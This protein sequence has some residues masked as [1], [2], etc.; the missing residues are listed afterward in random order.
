VTTLSPLTSHDPSQPP[1]GDQWWMASTATF[2]RRGKIDSLSHCF[3]IAKNWKH[4]I[5]AAAVE[6]G[7]DPS[8]V[9]ATRLPAGSEGA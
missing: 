1:A 9:I 8:L 2:N 7:A 3:V 6:L 4:A 5:D